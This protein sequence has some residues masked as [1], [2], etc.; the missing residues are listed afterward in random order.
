MLLS[1]IIFSTLIC[2][3][4]HIDILI[5]CMV[6][7]KAPYSLSYDATLFLKNHRDQL[8]YYVDY[9]KDIFH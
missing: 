5:T 2:C 4:S 9:V 6:C 1:D 8:G 7:T 3:V